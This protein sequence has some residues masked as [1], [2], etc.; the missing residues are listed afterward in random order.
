ML[1]P[2]KSR[3][4][5]CPIE[6]I[7]ANQSKY[8]RY[9]IERIHVK[10][11]DYIPGIADY[12]FKTIKWGRADPDNILILPVSASELPQRSPSSVSCDR[13]I[14]DIQAALNVSDEVAEAIL[15]RNSLATETQYR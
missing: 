12:A 1:I 4:R 15:N 6:H 8:A 9:G 7:E 5:G 3:F 13:G 14:K 2:P 10:Q 11:V